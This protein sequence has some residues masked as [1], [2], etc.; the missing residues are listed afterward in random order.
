[1]EKRYRCRLCTA[2]VPTIASVTALILPRQDV[3][4]QALFREFPRVDNPI[5]HIDGVLF[6]EVV[7]HP[8]GSGAR[9]QEH[10]IVFM[11]QG[12]GTLRDAVLFLHMEVVADR[13]F[14]LGHPG[15]RR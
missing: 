6:V 4:F 15:R 5:R 11:Y 3:G 9:I 2:S 12:G 8:L 1:M 14:I 10:K 7:D 13:G